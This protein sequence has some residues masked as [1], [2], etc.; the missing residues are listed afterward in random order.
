[1]HDLDDIT[2]AIVDAALKIHGILDQGSSSRSTK[3]FWP[4]NSTSADSQ[5]RS[6]TLFDSN[7]TAWC[8]RTA[9]TS[10]YS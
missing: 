10:T 3:S 1:M 5:W 6:I 4:G 9:S 2:G 8:S 7:T